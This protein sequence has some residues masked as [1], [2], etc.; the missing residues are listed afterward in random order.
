M[1]SQDN[2]LQTTSDIDTIITKLL[3]FDP[4]QTI[5]VLPLTVD[6]ISYL[7]Q[8]ATDIIMSQPILLELNAP[9]KVCGTS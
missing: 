8:V 1:I 5:K 3:E 6:E 4:L 7:L 2:C 9:V